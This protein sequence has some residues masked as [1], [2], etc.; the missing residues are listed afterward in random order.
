MYIILEKGLIAV[1]K[2][3]GYSLWTLGAGGVHHLPAIEKARFITRA[4]IAEIIRYLRS[5]KSIKEIVMLTKE[6]HENVRIILHRYPEVHK[7][8]VDTRSLRHTDKEPTVKPSTTHL[9][10]V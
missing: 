6:T 10:E 5:G 8:Y 4:I 1:H 7:I 3:I 9:R 2:V